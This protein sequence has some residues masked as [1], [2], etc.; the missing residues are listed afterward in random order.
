MSIVYPMNNQQV[1]AVISFSNV[2]PP[3][4]RILLGRQKKLKTRTLGVKEG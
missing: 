3:T 4:K 1:W 2:F